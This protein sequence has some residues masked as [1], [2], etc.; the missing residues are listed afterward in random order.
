MKKVN[1]VN[2]VLIELII[3]VLFFSI[4]SIIT[5]RLFAKSYS[6]TASSSAKT[7]LTAV[8]E[9]QMNDYRNKTV[10]EGD[11]VLFFDEKL[12][13]CEEEDAYYI[14]KIHASND[15]EMP[16]VNVEVNVIDDN[17]KTVLSF[18]TAFERQVQ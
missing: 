10:G 16:L 4:S 11:R 17:N 1:K 9:M 2:A 13:P 6:L 5:I 14:E 15:G 3:V 8:V 7:E 12:K 18:V